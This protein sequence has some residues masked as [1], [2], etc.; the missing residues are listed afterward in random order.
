MK[1][2]AFAVA[3][4]QAAA[5]LAEVE[6]CGDLLQ[7][8]H[9]RSGGSRAFKGISAFDVPAAEVAS[10]L[11]TR[12]AQY[13]I[14]AGG[15]CYR[16]LAALPEEEAAQAERHEESAYVKAVEALPKDPKDAG[17]WASFFISRN[18]AVKNYGCPPSVEGGR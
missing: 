16:M 15:L 6:K 9:R 3:A 5:G 14:K 13:E 11:E 2:G 1:T 7:A 10:R 4:G 18:P 17:R 12:E 8:K